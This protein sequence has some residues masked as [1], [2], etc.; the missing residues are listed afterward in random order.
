R[1]PSGALALDDDTF[2]EMARAHP[3]EIAPIRELRH[4]LGQLRLEELAVGSDARNRCLLSAFGS[5]TSRNQPSNSRF[6]FG[7]SCCLRSLFRPAR[8]QAVAYGDWCAQELGI[9]AALSH[10]LGMREAYVSGDPYI[11]MARHVGA[12][13][14]DATKKTHRGERE[15]FKVV[16]LGVLY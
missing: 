1:L 3:T 9:A 11:W 14:A 2:R 15:Q 7:P 8:G 5:K 4:T 16:S 13:P 6:I 12:V 10:D